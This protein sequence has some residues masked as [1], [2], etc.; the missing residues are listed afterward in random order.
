MAQLASAAR[1]GLVRQDVPQERVRLVRRVHL[2][3]DGTDA[4]HIV[5]W[6]D[7]RHGAAVRSGVP[8]ALCLPHAPPTLMAEAVSV[9][10]IGV[11]DAPSKSRRVPHRSG[12][13]QAADT[14]D[15]HT[16]GTSHRTPVF[17]RGALQPGDTLK[18]PAII[19][20]PTR[21]PLLNRAGRPT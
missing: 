20:G 17:R 1:G 16:G 4:A 18:G 5:G 10:A 8:P 11:S 19:A 2:R 9:E 3:Y 14:V 21:P 12:P 15:M 13:P 7:R 6:L